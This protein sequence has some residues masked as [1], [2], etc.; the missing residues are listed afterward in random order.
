[1]EELRKKFPEINARELF[2]LIPL[3]ISF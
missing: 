2:T 1:M 3:A